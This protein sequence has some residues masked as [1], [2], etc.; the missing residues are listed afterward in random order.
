LA[1][2]F[3]NLGPLGF[4]NDIAFVRRKP[5]LD[6]G[7]IDKTIGP[8]LQHFNL[9]QQTV[10]AVAVF[11][12]IPTELVQPPTLVYFGGCAAQAAQELSNGVHYRFTIFA[13]RSQLKMRRSTRSQ[14]LVALTSPRRKSNRT[15]DGRPQR[16][17]FK[18]V[19]LRSNSSISES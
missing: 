8:T 3:R 14:T 7:R 9:Q 6:S 4:V 5:P 10:V 1:N 12:S 19:V 13:L 17:D 15:G 18:R 16:S 11:V 2:T